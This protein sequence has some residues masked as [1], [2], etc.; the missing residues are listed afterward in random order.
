MRWRRQGLQ[1]GMLVFGK[2]LGDD[3]RVP[4]DGEI[5]AL[6]DDEIGVL[7]DAVRASGGAAPSS[8][9]EFNQAIAYVTSI[10]TR[11][12]NLPDIYRSFLEILHTYQEEQ[13]SV[14]HVLDQV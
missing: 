3:G 13:R 7:P 11:F 12:S 8:K 14:K 9:A 6:L 1:T 2:D 5:R 4:Q 10:K